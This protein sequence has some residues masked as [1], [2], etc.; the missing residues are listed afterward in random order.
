[1]DMALSRQDCA[2]ILAIIGVVFNGIGVAV[3]HQPFNLVA[4]AFSTVVLLWILWLRFAGRSKH[5]KSEG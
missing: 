3:G 5:S 4:F 2:A 1:M